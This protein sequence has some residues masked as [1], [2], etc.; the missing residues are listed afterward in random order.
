ME[1]VVLVENEGKELE[2]RNE[3]KS[4]QWFASH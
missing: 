1:K 3:N 4:H 2:A